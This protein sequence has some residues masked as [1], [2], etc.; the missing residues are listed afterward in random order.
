MWRSR[1]IIIVRGTGRG[2]LNGRNVVSPEVSFL[3]AVAGPSFLPRRAVPRGRCTLDPESSV[4]AS[5]TI[6]ESL[7]SWIAFDGASISRKSRLA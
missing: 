2:G 4:Y 6:H 3:R 5:G 7:T 1:T